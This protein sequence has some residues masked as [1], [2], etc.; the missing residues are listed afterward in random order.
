MKQCTKCL[1]SKDEEEFAWKKRDIRRASVCR[2]CQNQLAKAHYES[3]KQYYKD[4]SKRNRVSYRERGQKFVIEY[5][6]SHPCVD[7]GEDD[8]EVL[9]FDHIVELMDWR[10][11]RVAHFLSQSIARIEKEISKC[12]VRCANCHVRKTRRALGTLRK[13]V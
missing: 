6:K 8:V 4:K 7:C 9:Q 2:K 11:P 3:N 12:E 5:L 10:A 13:P 1:E